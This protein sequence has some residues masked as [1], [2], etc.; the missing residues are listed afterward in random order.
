MAAHPDAYDLDDMSGS[1][2]ASAVLSHASQNDY[3]DRDQLARLGKKSVL[4]RNF[5]FLSTVGFSCAVL[6]TWE[7]TLMSFAPGLL[8]GGSAGLIWS[9]LIVWLCNLSVFATLSELLSI[10]PT[11]GGQYH[12]VAMLAPRSCSKFLSYIT[13]WLTIGGWQGACASVGFLTG[14]MIQGLVIFTIPSYE[15]Q[16][17]QGTLL[18][19]IVVFLAVL[20]NTVLSAHLPKLE[21]MLLIVH[22]LGFF[23]IIIPLGIFG[24]HG[25]AS[26]VFTTFHNGGNW[27]TQVLSSFVGVVGVVFSFAGVDCTFHMCEEVRNPS[28]VVPRSIM[29]STLIN[30]SLGLAIIIAMAFCNTDIEAALASST[31]YPFIEIFYQTLASRAATTALASIIVFMTLASVIGVIATTSRMFWA[32]ARDRGLPFWRTLSK[33]DSTTCVPVWAIA[34]TSTISCLLGLINIGS[35]V[36]YNALVSLSISSLY[37]SYLVAASLLLYRRCTKGFR[38]PDASTLP[39]LAETSGRKLVWGSWRLHGAW[40]IANNAV[41][42]I[43]LTTVLFFSFWPPSSTVTPETM[44]FSV[45][46]TGSLVIFSIVYYLVWAKKD[47]KGPILET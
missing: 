15:P 39:A 1:K 16:P 33:V 10:A 13:A 6:I 31:G 30:G 27:S 3:Q 28:V 36:A 21:G 12:W 44:N 22:I 7:G 9:F 34:T 42:C 26:T 41:S 17:Y 47:Y 29:I 19:W 32:F 11:S 18:L 4:R 14:T 5:G 8:N 24:T 38:M 43:Y 35:K 37:G 20:C 46:I 2:T 40:G 23:A 25:D 45:L